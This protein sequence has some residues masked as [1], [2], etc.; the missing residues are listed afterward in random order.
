[1]TVKE[2]YEAAKEIYRAAGVDTDAALEA[3]KNIPVSMHCWQGDDV[4]GFDGAGALSGGIQATG[5]YPGRART[6]EELMSDMDKALSLIPGTHRINL[7]ASYAV[8]EDGEW[9]DR[10]K[11]EPKHFAKWVEFAKER[12]LGID[13]NP[14]LFSHVKAENATL[15]SEVPE[16]RRF[17]ID[18]VKACIRISEYFAQELGTPCTMNIWIPDGFKDIPADRTA[19]RA[20]L[21][22][23]LDQILSI[24]YDKSK[25]YVAVESK[26]FGIGMESCTVGSHE[27]Y[28][29][30]ASKNDILC[31][32]D[33]GHYH[34]T[35]VVS[36]KISSMLLF[37]DKVA[38]H[39]TRPVRW[40]SD[41]VVLFDD[42]TREIAK[43]IVRGGADRVLLA[44]DFF[45]A[46]INRISAWVVG[47]RNMQKA[48]LNA[49]L[50]PNGKMAELQNERKFTELMMLSEEMKTYPLG[51]VWDY[52][53][54]QN[55]A[56]VKEA[57]FEEVK[58]Y[59][60]DVLVKRS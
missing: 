31:L 50:L 1:M 2:R 3:L 25:V 22:D 8:F 23:S 46:S 42:E 9:A 41:H 6:P 20:R 26:V 36:D 53:C 48:L 33:S 44:L 15:S 13:F 38:L 52:F 10:D 49:L 18:H 39:V 58:R 30:Y 60:A 24:D 37:F 14:T 29:N 16:I 32:L 34:P 57:W 17:W 55:G 51:D 12:G 27:F 59:E 35:E 40:D 47:M 7:H 11:L 54:E 43:E 45:D 19:P 28:M 4:I 21:K 56:P 5:N